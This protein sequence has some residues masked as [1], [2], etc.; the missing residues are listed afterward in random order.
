MFANFVGGDLAEKMIGVANTRLTAADL[1]ADCL[2]SKADV[3]FP[4]AP[5]AV[6]LRYGTVF[7]LNPGRRAS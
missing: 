2:Q 6:R 7:R 1:A 5:S 3:G 4:E